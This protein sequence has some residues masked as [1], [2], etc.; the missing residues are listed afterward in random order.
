M[1]DSAELLA[2]LRI[3]RTA[4]QELLAALGCHSSNRDPLAEFAERIAH[5]ILGGQL[6]ASRTQKGYDLVSERGEKVQVKYLANSGESWVNEHEVKFTE[7]VDRYALLIVEDLDAKALVVFSKTGLQR[8]CT[9][10]G[11]RH[12]NQDRTLQFGR[13][14]YLAI[15]AAPETFAEY[16]V[17][18]VL[19]S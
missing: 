16:G 17:S 12:P 6:A 5:A 4:R 2:A 1:P 14:N 18:F 8:V 19:L 9:L 15:A 13:R 10:L 11:K 3:Y 7:D